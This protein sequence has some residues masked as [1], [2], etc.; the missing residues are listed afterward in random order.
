MLYFWKCYTSGVR[1]TCACQKWH[2]SCNLH[3]RMSILLHCYAKQLTNSLLEAKSGGYC[4]PWALCKILPCS[5]NFT[6]LCH[7]DN[8]TL[9]QSVKAVVLYIIQLTK[10]HT[11][12]N[13]DRVLLQNVHLVMGSV[14]K[15]YVNFIECKCK[16]DYSVMTT[17]L[18]ANWNLMQCLWLIY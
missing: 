11:N 1:L 4:I 17:I 16:N 10:T 3:F 7:I 13:F 9:L 6:E 15:S 12:V 2:C 14:W 5:L 18:H 8:T